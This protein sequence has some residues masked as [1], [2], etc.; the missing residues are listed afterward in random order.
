MVACREQ[1]ETGLGRDF[2]G[3]DKLRHR[4]L[5]VTEHEADELLAVQR[6]ICLLRAGSGRFGLPGRLRGG[7]LDADI[8]RCEQRAGRRQQVAAA[9]GK[10]GFGVHDKDSIECEPAM[11]RPR[12]FTPEIFAAFS[13]THPLGAGSGVATGLT[14]TRQ[15]G[16]NGANE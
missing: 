5:L 4:E 15:S 9:R 3:F 7:G 16:A 1:R 11:R 8:R 13:P 6:A 2:A 12:R 14:A 10:A